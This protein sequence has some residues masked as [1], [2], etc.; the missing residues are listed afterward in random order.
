MCLFLL[1]GS[2]DVFSYIWDA[3]VAMELILL[4][5]F[6]LND[7]CMF[8]M[9]YKCTILNIAIIVVVVVVLDLT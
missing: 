9:T 6:M 4:R 7:I 5:D 2:V 8:V 1:G 3:W